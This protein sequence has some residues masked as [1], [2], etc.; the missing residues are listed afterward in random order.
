MKRLEIKIGDRFN[1]GIIL[2]EIEPYISPNGYT[3]RKFE[4]KCDCGNVYS[5]DINSLTHNRSI[6]C[7]CYKKQNKTNL[8]HGECINGKWTKEYM[9]YRNIL[10]RCYDIK[11]DRYKD[12]G[13]RGITMCERWLESYEN[14]LEDMGRRPEGNYSIDRV[15]N[16]G[17][18][19]PTNCRWATDI[20]QR[21]NKIRKGSC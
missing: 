20:E 2:K 11:C 6:S 10:I 16:D 18:Y 14:F 5:V 9:T 12:Y 15:D 13:G 4:L 19:E 17:N 21:N 1:Y 7:G 8:K 3:R